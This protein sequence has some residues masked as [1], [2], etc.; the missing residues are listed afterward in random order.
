MAQL[1]KILIAVSLGTLMPSGNTSAAEWFVS[2]TG[3]NA[4]G[5]GSI[6][7]PFRTL[8]HLLEPANALVQAGDIVSLRGPVGNNVYNECDVR[9]RVPLT[10]RSHAGESAR[11]HCDINVIDSVTVQIDPDASGSR[12]SRIELSGGYYYALFFQTDWD[13]TGNPTGSG[14]SNVIVEDCVIRD[15]GRDAI[16]ITP[17]SNDITIR[18]CE[19]HHT[20]RIYPPG[21]PLDDKNAE[22]I[23][24]VNGARMRVEDS[25]VHDT[26][27]TGIY[28]K[29]G[30]TDVIVQRNVVERAGAAG[31][32]VGFDTSPE[33][34][35]L[36]ANPGYYEAIRGIVR[37]NI[38]RDTAYAGIGLYAARDSIVA[39]NTLLRTAT[40]AQAALYFGVTLQDFDPMAGRPPTINPR[41]LNNLVV[42]NGGD[43]VGIRWAN[44]ISAAGLYGLQGDPGSD[45]NWFHNTNGECNFSDTR[46][47][48]SI[49]NGGNFAAWRAEE[50]ADANSRTG[51][52]S[53]ALDGRLVPGSGAIDQGVTLPEVIDDIDATARSAPYDIGADE[54][55]QGP[56]FRNSFE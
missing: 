40:L 42:Q 32:L 1:I 6:A 43:C 52:V 4:T 35:D 15:S 3:N 7:A 31:I 14:A 33:F 26:A 21:T 10:I 50:S 29:G 34:F 23:D 39:N 36:S 37:N 2:T 51:S 55:D 28:F 5:T 18:R 44:E 8:T 20:G 19:I 11:I 49:D 17:K 13:S 25:Y 45:Y 56:L 9:L 41:I 54:L 22:G 46:P 12:L 48:S 27:T 24:N 16:K 47:G 53:L 30:A 38:V